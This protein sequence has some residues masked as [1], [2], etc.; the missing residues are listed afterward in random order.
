MYLPVI[1]EGLTDIPVCTV[2]LV[3]RL[4]TPAMCTVA[5]RQP[6]PCS[7]HLFLTVHSLNQLLSGH[8]LSYS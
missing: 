4:L 3:A 5:I 7:G 1:E 6:F 2:L 8:F